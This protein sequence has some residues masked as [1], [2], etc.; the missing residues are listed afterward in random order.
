MGNY[1]VKKCVYLLPV[2]GLSS[3]RGRQAE[4]TCTKGDFCKTLQSS[5]QRQTFFFLC[6]FI[7]FQEEKFIK[8]IVGDTG[9]ISD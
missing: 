3:H 9:L 8:C 4:A 5:T 6:F 7:G 2:L 1:F